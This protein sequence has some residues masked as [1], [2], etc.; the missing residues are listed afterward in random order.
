MFLI[1]DKVAV[2]GWGLWE[3]IAKILMG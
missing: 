1:F 2:C 3:E